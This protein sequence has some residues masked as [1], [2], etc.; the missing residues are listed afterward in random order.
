MPVEAFRSGTQQVQH[1]PSIRPTDTLGDLFYRKQVCVLAAS[2]S[3]DVLS[4]RDGTAG[5]SEEAW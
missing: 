2:H 3:Q 4:L 5:E 1:L